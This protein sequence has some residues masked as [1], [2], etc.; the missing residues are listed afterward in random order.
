MD[1][2][3][4][5]WDGSTPFRTYLCQDSK[6][7]YEYSDENNY[8]P[9][10]GISDSGDFSYSKNAVRFGTAYARTITVSCEKAAAGDTVTITSTADDGYYCKSVKVNGGLVAVR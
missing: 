3:T 2:N 10:N 7:L 9:I 6:S 8:D 1:D 4:G 5:G